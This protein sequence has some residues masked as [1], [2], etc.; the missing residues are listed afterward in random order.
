MLPV[1][2]NA[3]IW[4]ERIFIYFSLSVF[5]PEFSSLR[6]LTYPGTHVIL[7]C[8]S[9]VKP[10]SFRSLRTTWLRELAASSMVLN[11]AATLTSSEILRFD[12]SHSYVTAHDNRVKSKSMSSGT[13][14]GANGFEPVPGPAFLLIGCA[15]DLRNDISHLLE[16][17]KIGE[18]PVDKKTAETLALEL[19]AEAYVECSAL[20]QKNLKTVFDLAVWCGLRIADAGGPASKII[21]SVVQPTNGCCL[22]NTASQTVLNH[23]SND[24]STIDPTHNLYRNNEHNKHGNVS[25]TNGNKFVPMPKK[26]S[27]SCKYGWRKFFCNL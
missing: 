10:E 23:L 7:L 3:S 22:I 21:S 15:C 11:R 9:V 12:S 20:T 18:E 19:G 8:F 6:Q 24:K 27:K 25:I 5:Q 13:V 4:I 2:L 14:R 16:L 17:S 26:S 1:I